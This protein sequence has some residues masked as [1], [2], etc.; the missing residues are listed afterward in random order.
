MSTPLPLSDADIAARIASIA[1]ATQQ[2]LT[3]DDTAWIAGNVRRWLSHYAYQEAQ[4]LDVIG[5]W[6]HACAAPADMDSQPIIIGAILLAPFSKGG[7]GNAAHMRRMVV[8]AVG[9]PDHRG[10]GYWTRSLTLRGLDNGKK[11]RHL[12]PSNCLV[13]APTS[14][15][16]VG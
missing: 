3:A 11:I 8:E 6:V 4:L 2:L 13:I 1:G 16:S 14:A 5:T 10:Y 9:E 15:P 7:A 12:Y